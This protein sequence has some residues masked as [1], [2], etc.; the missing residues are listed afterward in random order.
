Q[1]PPAGPRGG[2]VEHGRHVAGRHAAQGARRTAKPY[3]NS[4]RRIADEHETGRQVLELDG[5]PHDALDDP[6]ACHD[7]PQ[8]DRD[9]RRQKLQPEI[10]KGMVRHQPS[11]YPACRGLL[12]VRRSVTTDLSLV[13]RRSLSMS[14]SR[15]PSSTIEIRPVSSD[16]TIATAS[17]SSVTPIA[18]R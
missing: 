2:K 3:F 10:A 8:Q 16:T 5:G 9:Q 1:Q 14:C 18:A 12:P 17:F 13:R 6:L 11:E 4:V 7:E 15:L